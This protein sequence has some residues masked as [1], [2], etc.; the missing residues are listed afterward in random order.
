M[1]EE[2]GEEDMI[3]SEDGSIS[4]SDS[5]ECQVID[6]HQCIPTSFGSRARG[7]KALPYMNIIYVAL[8]PIQLKI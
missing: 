1:E 5:N 6:I 8:F 2:T 7:W 3:M 4:K